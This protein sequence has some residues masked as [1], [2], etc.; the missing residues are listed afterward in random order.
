MCHSDAFINSYIITHTF[1]DA[2]SS[3]EE[4]MDQYYNDYNG[5]PTRAAAN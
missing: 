2:F 1:A 3:I 5:K 4:I